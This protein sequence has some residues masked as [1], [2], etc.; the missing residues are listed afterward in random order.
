MG[1]DKEQNVDYRSIKDSKGSLV[2]KG[3][4]MLNFE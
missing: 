4:Q 3:R 1:S 2:L